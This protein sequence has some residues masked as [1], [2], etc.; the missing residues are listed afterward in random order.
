MTFGDGDYLLVH[1]HPTTCDEYVYPENFEK[2]WI[3][4][5]SFKRLVLG[6]THI[7]H[8]TQIDDSLIVNPGSVG[9]PRDGNPYAAYVI[10]D[11]EIH[12]VELYW[13]HYNIDR[14]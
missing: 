14:V 13:A 7:Q 8:R 10:L 11:T 9:Q 4:L 5:D 12:D 1:F 3:Y 2:L 6:H